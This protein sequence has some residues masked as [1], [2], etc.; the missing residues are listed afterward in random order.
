MNQNNGDIKFE[1]A[2]IEPD[3]KGN[4]VVSELE[5]KAQILENMLEAS[6]LGE[7]FNVIVATTP[8]VQVPIE[9]ESDKILKNIRTGWD[10]IPIWIRWILKVLMVIWPFFLTFIAAGGD[11]IINNTVNKIFPTNDKIELIHNCDESNCN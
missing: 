2:D 5:P 8:N 6:A 10:K 11:S 4:R 1:P 3:I 9:R 7:G